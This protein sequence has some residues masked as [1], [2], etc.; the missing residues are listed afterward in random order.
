MYL[1][2]LPNSSDI[3]ASELA[4]EYETVSIVLLPQLWL[5][6]KGGGDVLPSGTHPQAGWLDGRIPKALTAQS[7]DAPPQTT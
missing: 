3:P 6:H 2:K 5:L 1:S 7:R 4:F